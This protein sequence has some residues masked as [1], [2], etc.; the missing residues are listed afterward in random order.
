MKQPGALVILFVFVAAVS[1]GLASNQYKADVKLRASLTGA[2]PNSKT[3]DF[4]GSGTLLLTLNAAKNQMCYELRVSN[5][6]D[7]T[8]AQLLSNKAGGSEQVVLRLP[9]PTNGLAK[10]CTFLDDERVLEIVQVPE[11]HYITVGSSDF[12]DEALRGQLSR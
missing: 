3:G 10:G 12:P 6:A 1:F 4:D 11:H 7:A 5:I 9:P 8:S 2:P